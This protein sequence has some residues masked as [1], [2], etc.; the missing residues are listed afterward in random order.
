MLHHEILETLWI[1]S[2]I[3]YF[4]IRQKRTV[5]DDRDGL[6]RRVPFLVEWAATLLL[7][8]LHP[9]GSIASI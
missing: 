4:I 8:S 5:L 6:H 3:Y 7:V 1:A 9:I 2:T